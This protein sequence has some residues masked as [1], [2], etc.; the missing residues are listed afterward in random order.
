[1]DLLG[2]ALPN[3]M[4]IIGILAI[5]L[6]LGI[7][8]KIISLNKEIDK[9]G[10]IG[11]L[12]V[13]VILIGASITMYLNP[14]LGNRGQQSS[15]AP[16]A[17]QVA[18]AQAKTVAATGA[19]AATSA[20]LAPVVPAQMTVPTQAAAPTSTPVLGFVVP[21]LHDLSEKDAQNK[22]VDAHL[23]PHKADHCV[24]A[25][26][27]DQKAKK[28]RIMCQNPPVGQKVASGTTVDY[29]LAGK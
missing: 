22:L 3:V 12:V 27:G 24:G 21:D 9:T 29:V 14:S 4:F 17:A 1:M 23:K 15:A 7:E 13:G 6:G 26:P 8:L 19:P 28:G 16:N 11:A 2:T 25:N 20:A 10:R 18:P 5:G